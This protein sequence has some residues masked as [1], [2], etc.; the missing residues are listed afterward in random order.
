MRHLAETTGATSG[1]FFY[2]LFIVLYDI[3]LLT[4]VLN[5]TCRLEFV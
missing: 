3:Y 5:D 4:N 2:T 1:V